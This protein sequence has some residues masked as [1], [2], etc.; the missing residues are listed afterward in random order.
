[1][2]GEWEETNEHDRNAVSKMFDDLFQEKLLGIMFR[3]IG[4]NRPPNPCS[5]Q[6]IVFVSLWLES[7]WTE[8]LDLAWKYLLTVFYG[9]SR[10]TNWLKKALEKSDNSPNVKAEKCVK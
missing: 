2:I 1:M 3:L 9:D 4:V 10:V 8:V 6:I 5:F 7:K